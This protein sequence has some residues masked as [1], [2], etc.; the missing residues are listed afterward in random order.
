MDALA[1]VSGL[2]ACPVCGESLK[3]TQGTERCRQGHSFDIARQG[4]LNLLGGPQPA[5]ADTAT[6]VAA[7]QRFLAA[8]HYD[9]IAAEVARR[10]A[11]QTI[12]LE[13]GAGPGFYLARALDER[14][15]SKGVS[16]DVSV[17]AAKAAARAHPRAAS[18]VADVWQK[19][20]IR[21]GRVGGVAAVFAPRNLPEFARVL[22]QGGTLVVVLP[23]Q[24]HLIG[25]RDRYNLLDVGA[26]KGDRLLRDASGFFEPL[27]TKKL[28]YPVEATA[29][30]VADLI[31]MGP[32]AFHG[33]PT[34]VEPQVL[35][36]N[37]TVHWFRRR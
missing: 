21:S 30:Q 35:D 24:D 26:D 33:V 36:V 27:G 22:A 20:P 32:N 13:V 31:A 23:E 5:N 8:G 15:D 18:V 7:R 29:G 1:P 25:V 19:L 37:V 3:L 12:L 16:L 10:L 14:P 11:A 17:A 28:R 34:Q 9:P 4:Y 2:L 6:M